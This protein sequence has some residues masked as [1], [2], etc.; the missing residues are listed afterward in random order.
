M[1]NRDIIRSI[2]ISEIASGALEIK[3]HNTYVKEKK[4]SND[5][6]SAYDAAVGFIKKKTGGNSPNDKQRQKRSSLMHYLEEESPYS[7]DKMYLSDWDEDEDSDLPDSPEDTA[8]MTSDKFLVKKDRK[9]GVVHPGHK[10]V[11]GGGT[12]KEDIFTVKTSI[13]HHDWNN[14]M[15]DVL[16]GKK[17]LKRGSGGSEKKNS[18]N[19]ED[20]QEWAQ[21]KMIQQLLID[22]GY[23]KG[24]F[25]SADGDFG[26]RTRSAV[27]KMQND[28]DLKVDG[29]IG[30]Q[31]ATA[32]NPSKVGS[33]IGVTGSQEGDVGYIGESKL[34][35]R[36]LRRIIK[37]E[38]SFLADGK[39]ASKSKRK[40]Y[41]GGRRGKTESQAQQ[42]A[43]GIA[44]AAREKGSKK[45]AIASLKGSSKEMAKMSMKDLRR[46]ATIRRGS[47]V[48]DSTKKGKKLK[49]LPGRIAE[50]AHIEQR[51]ITKKKR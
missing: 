26:G 18:E 44:L 24:L 36:Q 14:V 22:A 51:A 39:K 23:A 9:S 12:D 48:P 15:A 20:R 43:A 8:K 49:A 41:K 25:G 19:L 45:S 33:K 40:P 10:I 27:A 6:E 3:V 37:E 13:G 17:L 30:R 46:L 7:D 34:S 47:E 42:K 31:T 50:T 5:I 28:L 16:D 1:S 11:T 38:L 4:K 21:V 2:V 32:F 35:R 29:V